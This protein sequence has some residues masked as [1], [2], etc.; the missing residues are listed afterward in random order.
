MKKY[1]KKIII[2]GALGQDGLI[3]SKLF[4][5]NKFDVKIMMWKGYY[6]YRIYH[7]CKARRTKISEV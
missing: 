4:I 6:S 3:L 1:K 2:T 7:I 5:E